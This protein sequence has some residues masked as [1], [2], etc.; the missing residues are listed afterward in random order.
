MRELLA[1]SR[2]SKL[3]ATGSGML[4]YQPIGYRI[5]GGDFTQFVLE[6]HTNMA[7]KGV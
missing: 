7:V 2:Q 1:V 4:E 3:T 5:D 6:A